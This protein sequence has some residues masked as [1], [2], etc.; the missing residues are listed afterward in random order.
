MV[1]HVFFSADLITKLAFR[2]KILNNKNILICCYITVTNSHIRISDTKLL[3][4]GR[5]HQ[6]WQ[7]P[8]SVPIATNEFVAQY[9]M[10]DK[11]C[12]CRQALP[13]QKR[14]YTN[15]ERKSID[16]TFCLIYYSK[17]WKRLWLICFV[18]LLFVFFLCCV[19][20]PPLRVSLSDA[21]VMA[22]HSVSAVAAAATSHMSPFAGDIQFRQSD[23]YLQWISLDIHC[24]VSTSYVL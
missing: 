18:S 11:S 20:A 1:E 9:F 19:L 7:L 4:F 15:L 14:N 24:I 8:L 21:P 22:W 3:S 10:A 17:R 6:S 16:S 13:A 2:I 23:C 12:E 5:A